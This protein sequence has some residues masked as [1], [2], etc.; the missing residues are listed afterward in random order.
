MQQFKFYNPTKIHFG[1]GELNNIAQIVKKY[2][3]KCMLVT[4]TNEEQVLRP[5]YDRVKD[6]LAKGGIDVLHFDEVVPNP[7]VQGIEKAIDIVKSQGIQVVVAVGG[8]SSIDT[9]KAISLFYQPDK[10]DWNNAYDKFTSPFAEYE[11]ISDPVLPLITVPT[12]AGTGSEL[13][14]AMIIS[15]ETTEEKVCI[16]HNHV[17]PKESVID[18]E[19]TVTMPRRLTAMTGFD[20]FSHAFESYMRNEA[21]VYTK[22][23]GNKAIE[24]IIYALPR[25][26]EDSTNIELREMMSVAEMFAGI[27]LSNAAATIPHPL[28]EV[29]GGIAPQIPHGQAL[30]SLYPGFVRFQI[31]KTPKKCAE[32][33]RLFDTDLKNVDDILAASKLPIFVE[34]FLKKLGLNKSL[35]ELGVTEEEKEKMANHFLLGVL[36]FGTKE[37]L[38]RILKESF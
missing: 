18:V 38:T 4:T 1:A 27:S 11:T 25:L 5:L 6:I 13:T 32:I 9:A 14:Q 28:S 3:S 31:T 30:A 10:I 35:T 20:A 24:N 37:E 12:T 34:E 2:G 19:L 22:T 23:I 26:M 33:A 17:F 8:G 16:F 36:P 21:S 15:D 29:I 7:T